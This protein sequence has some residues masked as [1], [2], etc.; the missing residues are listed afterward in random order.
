MNFLTLDMLR[1]F[2]LSSSGVSTVD[3]VRVTD[4]FEMQ[5]QGQRLMTARGNV[6]VFRTLDAAY[7]Y[8]EDHLSTS[9]STIELSICVGQRDLLSV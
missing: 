6:R 4:G 2:I 1:G 9:N 5:I 8:A 3:L 7:R